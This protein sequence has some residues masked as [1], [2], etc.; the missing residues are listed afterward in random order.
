M[1][2]N[3]KF[4]RFDIESL[5]SLFFLFLLSIKIGAKYNTLCVC[6]SILLYENFQE[7]AELSGKESIFSFEFERTQ[8]AQKHR[9]IKRKKNLISPHVQHTVK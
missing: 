6:I 3:F 9:K 2:K 7:N 4:T 8:M 5:F 1:C